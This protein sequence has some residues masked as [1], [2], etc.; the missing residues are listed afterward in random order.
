MLQHLES[1][2]IIGLMLLIAMIM[3]LTLL[4]KLTPEAVDAIKWVGSSFFLVRTGANIAE[5]LG[6]KTA[7][8]AEDPK[9]TPNA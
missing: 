1:K 8:K 2:T 3:S 5:N 6:S 4:G 7:P 9:E